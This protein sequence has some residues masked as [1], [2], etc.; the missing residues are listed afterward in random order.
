MKEQTEWKIS[1]TT[2][3]IL[4]TTSVLDLSKIRKT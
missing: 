1:V 3:G 2:S 4:Y